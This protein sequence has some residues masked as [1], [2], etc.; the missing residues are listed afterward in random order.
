[1]A[2]PLTPS[3]LQTAAHYFTNYAV[4]LPDGVSFDD[5]LDPGFWAHL[6]D[7]LRQH[8]TIRVIPE[9]GTYFA[10]L[11]VIAAGRGFAKVKTLRHVGLTDD[12]ISETEVPEGIVVKWRGPHAKWCIERVIGGSESRLKEGIAEK[13]DAYREA[14]GYKLAA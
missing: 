8:D 7:K 4:V 13:A 6:G 10:E 12:E 5:A 2:A 3:R 14:A 11:L 9:D 1:M